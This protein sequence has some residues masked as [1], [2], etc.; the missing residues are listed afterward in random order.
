MPGGSALAC[1]PCNVRDNRISQVEGGSAPSTDNTELKAKIAA[2][3]TE[4][5]RT[6]NTVYEPLGRALPIPTARIEHPR[7]GESSAKI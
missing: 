5:V 1:S 7:F 6:M 2:L 4:D 3:E